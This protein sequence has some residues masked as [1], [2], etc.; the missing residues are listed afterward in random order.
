MDILKNILF[1]IFILSAL[2][3]IQKAF[4]QSTSSNLSSKISLDTPIAF[5]KDI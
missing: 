5:P 3:Y 1:L 2:F 4:S